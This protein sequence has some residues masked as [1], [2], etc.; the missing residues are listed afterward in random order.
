VSPRAREG[1]AARKSSKKSPKKAVRKAVKKSTRTS[2]KTTKK[3][4]RKS[5]KKAVKKSTT[6][7]KSIKTQSSVPSVIGLIALVVLALILLY[8]GVTSLLGSQ[9]TETQAAETPVLAASVNGVDITTV[10]LE[11]QY[12]ILPEQYRAVYT[13]D[14]ILQQLIDEEL[15][16][17]YGVDLG[18]VATDEAV[19]EEIQNILANGQITITELQSNLEKFNLTIDDFEKLIERKI[20][21][22]LSMNE[23]LKDVPQATVGDANAYYV[24]NAAQYVEEEQVRVRHIL[25]GRT[26][27]N[28]AQYSK[29]LMEQIKGG[30]D[31]CALVT[32]ETD[33][34]G[35]ADKCGEYT[36]ARG[37]MVPEF[38]KASFA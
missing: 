27:D 8:F 24:A 36:F 30:A 25:I 28:A 23:L 9:D 6:S 22:E 1:M 11:T 18:L 12:A 17:S 33:D 31:F 21:I 19:N 2:P 13:K 37:F 10:Q 16:I 34:K 5:P 4:P 14:M 3:A 29:D 32:K 38:E 35:S 7:K 26:R 15:L 20:L